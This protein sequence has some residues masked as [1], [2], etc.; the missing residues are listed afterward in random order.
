[1]GREGR[2]IKENAGQPSTH[3]TQSG[4]RVSQ[5]L[6][7]VRKAARENKEMRFTALLH[8]LTVDRS[9]A[10][11]CT[12]PCPKPVSGSNRS[13]E[14]T[15]TTTRY[16]ATPLAYLG[17]GIGRLCSGGIVF[18]A[19]AKSAGSPGPECLTWL[20]AG[21]PAP[22]VLHPYPDARFAATHPR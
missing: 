3:L 16:Q 21:Y 5:G 6:A 4:E 7:G 8:H 11:E 12:I 1:M 20:P 9:S 14:A 22:Q 2:L 19:A 15:S 10:S 13:S 18:A 17:S